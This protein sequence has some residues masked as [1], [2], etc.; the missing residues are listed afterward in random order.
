ML[1][2]AMA[3]VSDPWPVSHHQA[4]LSQIAHH[5]GPYMIDELPRD[6]EHDENDA[7][8]CSLLG[9][10]S[11]P[12]AL[13]NRLDL[14]SGKWTKEEEQF[15]F[16]IIQHFQNGTLN[17]PETATLRQCLSVALNCDAMRISKKFAGPY[18]IG[19]QVFTPLD[20]NNSNYSLMISVSADELNVAR[21]NWFRKLDEIENASM[22]RSRKKLR[23]DSKGNC[24]VVYDQQTVLRDQTETVD[25][26][27]FHK[28]VLGL[29]SLKQ[30][31]A[32]SCYFPGAVGEMGRKTGNLQMLHDQ[33]IPRIVQSMEKILNGE[34]ASH[35]PTPLGG[36]Y[37][38]MQTPPM[39]MWNPQIY[40][41]PWMLGQAVPGAM[42][43]S[44]GKMQPQ[45]S[46][47]A[48]KD[49]TN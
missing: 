18:S 6:E 13:R 42:Y 9:T 25:L 37:N 30:N 41:Q 36:M 40:P 32:D 27:S 23:L 43:V 46:S 1:P 45:D 29:N 19:K 26:E 38:P 39:Q 20:K 31:E 5:P 16:T 49:S 34:F 10:L 33:K 15:A 22:S 4:H 8:S 47:V 35:V 11:V 2:T 44:S 7:I 14:R 48:V 17:V 21:L 3:S 24:T 28:A 12:N